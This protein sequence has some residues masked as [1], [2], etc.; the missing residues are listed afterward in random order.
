MFDTI[1]NLAL[2]EHRTPVQ[3][4]A[5]LRDWSWC[6][7]SSIDYWRFLNQCSC[8]KVAP[9]NSATHAAVSGCGLTLSIGDLRTKNFE[10]WLPF[11]LQCWVNTHFK[12]FRWAEFFVDKC[13]T[14]QF[15]QNGLIDTNCIMS[16]NQLVPIR[17]CCYRKIFPNIATMHSAQRDLQNEW[18][19]NIVAQKE[20]I[21]S[22]VVSLTL[23]TT[24]GLET[25]AGQPDLWRVW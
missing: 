12:G 22:A 8:A 15:L 1:F 24:T 14:I 11:E 13:G 7:I 16:Q 18:S 20:Y 9:S 3:C 4:L 6:R 17:P 19:T 10:N 2:L 25:C 21:T 5:W 23:E